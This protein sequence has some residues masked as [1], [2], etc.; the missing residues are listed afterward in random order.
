MSSRIPF[1]LILCTGL[2][3]ACGHRVPEPRSVASD[4]PYVSWIV[5]SGGRDSPDREFICQSDPRN[6]CVMPASKPDQPVFANVHVYYH[7]AGADTKY[8]GSIQIGFFE[9]SPESQVVRP[10]ITVARNKSITNQSFVN[11]L[12][13]NPGT[14]AMRFELVAAVTGAEKTHTIR[15]EVPVQLE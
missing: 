10:N 6:E 4:T 3:F 14:Y 5:M 9:G 1:V 8:T 7:G 15:F 2:T 11:R 12:S 13:S